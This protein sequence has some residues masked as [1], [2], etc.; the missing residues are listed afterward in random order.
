MKIAKILWLGLYVG[1]P[2]AALGQEAN[3]GFELRSTMTVEAINSPQL[4]SAPRLG[5]DT[6]GGFRMMFYPTWK[7]SRHWTVTGAV[8]V[9]SR[10]FFVEELTTQGYGVRGDVLQ[11]HLD[12]S[13]FWGHSSVVFRAGELSS[14]FGSFLLRYDDAANPLID[15]PLSYG[16]YYKSV[17]SNSLAGAQVDITSG[18]WDARAQLTSSSPYSRLSVFDRG[19]AA[20]WTAG[21]GYTIR[22]GLRVGAS[23]FRGAYSYS[24]SGD[25]DGA[26]DHWMTAG[27]GAD[28]AWGIGHWNFAGEEQRFQGPF[29]T[30]PPY[31]REAGYAEARRTVGP[32][33]YVASRVGYQRGNIF[34][35]RNI[36]EFAV[37]FR[38][39]A[40]QLVKAGYEI[41]Q[42]NFIKGAS[43]NV[44]TLQ[45]VT[46]LRPLTFA[47]K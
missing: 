18:R 24:Y 33:W 23:A 28:I 42:G 14:A 19:Q 27:L 44:L 8:Q 38:P 40:S 37:G 10:P 30:I 41:E 36:Y 39:N 9:H 29:Q 15:Y 21:A 5:G 7:L 31:T 11:G 12:Y 2:F 17:T 25:S 46:T 16:Y 45:I 6:T 1:L 20:N 26:D 32:R 13:R 43:A 22:Q 34:I 4:S 3:S 47:G 35:A